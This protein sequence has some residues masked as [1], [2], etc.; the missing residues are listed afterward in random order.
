M[1]AESVLL[2]LG[3][4]L[5]AFGVGFAARLGTLCAGRLWLLIHAWLRERTGG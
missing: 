3:L 1:L 4:S 2:G 5:A